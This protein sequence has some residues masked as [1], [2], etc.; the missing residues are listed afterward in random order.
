MVRPINS[1]ADVD[2]LI[3]FSNYLLSKI[4]KEKNVSFSCLSFKVSNHIC[5]Q[6]YVLKHRFLLKMIIKSYFCLL[7]FYYIS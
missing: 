4:K 6:K 5:D 2:F 7:P 1:I 3:L